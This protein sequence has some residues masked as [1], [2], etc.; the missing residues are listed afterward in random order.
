MRSENTFGVSFFNR[1][2]KNKRKD[3]T[4]FARIL[5]N[6]SPAR[7]LSIKGGFDA[8][9]WDE[10]K[11]WPQLFTKELREFATHLKKV[12]SKL[13]AIYQDLELKEGV[14]TAEN[15]KNH[16]QGQ[17]DGLERVRC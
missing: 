2:N 6:N 7:E 4:V 8:A 12:E 5:C 14:F 15:I 10:G 3:Y 13:T 17:G 11:G 1:Q 16:Y 9:S